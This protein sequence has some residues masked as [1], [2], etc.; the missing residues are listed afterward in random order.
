MANEENPNVEQPPR[1]REAFERLLPLVRAVPEAEL[2]AIITDVKASVTTVLGAWA[3][4]R[5]LRPEFVKQLPT[6]DIGV[7]DRLESCALALGFAHTEYQTAT[8]PSASLVALSDQVVKMR[9]LLLSEVNTLILRELVD[10]KAI[11]DLKGGTG[12]KNVAFDLFALAN[13]FKKNWAKVSARTTLKSEDLDRA[14]NLADKLV[15]TVGL[16]EQA[17]VVSAEAVRDRQA[18]YTLLMNTYEEV[19]LAIGFIRRKQ[20]DV[21]SIAPSLYQGRGPT[22]KKKEAPEPEIVPPTAPAATAPAPSIKQNISA[23]GPFA[24]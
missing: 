3:E 20:G 2:L 11:K 6:F 8:E 5:N 10:P 17:P 4:I 18:A 15:T 13:V 24:E 7:F 12:Y 22:S 21:D 1:F 16:K 19:R 23:T 14:E 9:D